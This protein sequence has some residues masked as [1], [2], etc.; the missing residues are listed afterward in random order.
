MIITQYNEKQS[1][2][3]VKVENDH[4]DNY[5]VERVNPY[6]AYGHHTAYG[7]EEKESYARVA[8]S[9]RTNL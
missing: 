9:Q 4:N 5:R 6:E 2:G 7:Y 3:V 1:L 8:P